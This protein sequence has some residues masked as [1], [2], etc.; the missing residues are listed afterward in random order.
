MLSCQ[1]APR[2]VTFTDVQS[3]VAIK[4][5]IKL[6]YGLKNGDHEDR[7]VLHQMLS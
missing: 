3:I 4:F 7:T 2:Q 5:K 1:T 6:A